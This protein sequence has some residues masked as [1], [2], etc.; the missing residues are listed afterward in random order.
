MAGVKVLQ[1]DESVILRSD[2]RLGIYKRLSENEYN[3]IQKKITRIHEEESIL[4]MSIS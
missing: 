1:N 2:Q 3:F 4:S